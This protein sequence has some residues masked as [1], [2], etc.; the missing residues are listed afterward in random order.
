VSDP[1]SLLAAFARREREAIADGQIDALDE[2]ENT[3]RELIMRL[4]PAAPESARAALEAA[5]MAL[6]S[7]I[8][9]IEMRLEETRRELSQTGRS[10]QF[11]ASYG[12][13]EAP[14]ALDATG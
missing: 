12:Q 11:A 1:Y 13:G 6:A 2:T 9:Q 14:P 7:G 10:R 8:A 5:Q 3:W 4:P